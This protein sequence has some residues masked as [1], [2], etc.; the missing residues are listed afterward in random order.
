MLRD[1]Q[2][3]W[4]TQTPG[5]YLVLVSFVFYLLG[6]ILGRWL[7]RRVNVELGWTSHVFIV[8]ASITLA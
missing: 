3:F 8:S 6:L 2:S 7:K 4:P 5:L 1:F